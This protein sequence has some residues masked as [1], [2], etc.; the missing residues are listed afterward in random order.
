LSFNTTSSVI[1]QV[2]IDADMSHSR[3]KKKR[4]EKYIV[5]GLP[6][7]LHL[8]EVLTPTS[9][10]EIETGGTSWHPR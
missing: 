6:E 3:K 1:H 9:G 10:K 5:R 7:S 8:S 4:L 2:A